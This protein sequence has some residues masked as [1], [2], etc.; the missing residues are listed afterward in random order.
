M[1]KVLLIEK[2]KQAKKLYEEKGW[3]IPRIVVALGSGRRHVTKW[4]NMGDEELEKD[5]RGW[6][7][8]M[9]RRYTK[10][11]KE[12][13]KKIRIRLEKENS[14]FIGAPVVL[15][16]YN[17]QHKANPIS[18]I[19]FVDRTLKEA[20]LTKI[21]QKKKRGVSKYMEYPNRTL[22]KLGKCVMSVDF[23]GPKY[24]KGGDEVSFLSCKYIRPSKKGVVRRVEGQTT[25]EAIR[26]LKDI[27]QT[28][29]IPDVLQIDNDSAFG[30]IPLHEKTIG[31][32]TL[33]LLNL[34][35]KPLYIAPRSPWN[36]GNVEGHNSVFSKKFWNKIRFTDE[37]E[38]DVKIEG[39]NVAYEKYS[40]L[41]NGNP[42]LENPK[43][44]D[45]LKDVDPGNKEVKKFK[46]HEIRFL[47][48]VRRKGEK[49]D[50]KERG[51]IDVLKHEIELPVKLINLF[52]YCVLDLKKKKLFCY[53]EKD[54]GGLKDAKKVDFKVKGVIY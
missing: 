50:E 49:G 25:D 2:R 43:F 6:K 39:F 51:F 14:F 18:S 27:W 8:G 53:T 47:R 41:I 42:P 3:S 22:N 9:L 52:V 33:F 34:G 44:I 37:D 36:N 4:L 54:G 16:N 46:E 10:E 24:L 12:G 26:I 7:K 35:V 20:E 48:I 13:V 32:F 11:Q 40:D 28:E 30:L 17:K 1:K 21:P 38:I 29:P 45:D 5:N 15:N 23:I 31:R 19:R